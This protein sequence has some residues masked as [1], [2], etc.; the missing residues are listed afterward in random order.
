MISTVIL[1][2][3][4]GSR[5]NI[6]ENKVLLPL[7]GE[8]MFLKA[9]RTLAKISDELI[10]VSNENDISKIKRYVPHVILGGATRQ[11]SVYNGVKEAKGD[12]VIIHDGARPFVYLEDVKSLIDLMATYDVAFI[13]HNVVNSLK[14]LSFKNVDRNKLVEAYTPQIVKRKIYLEAYQKASEKKLTFTDDVTLVNEM[15]NKG[16][17]YVSSDNFYLKVTTFKDYELLLRITNDNYRIGHSWDTHLLALGRKLILGGVQIPF[18]KGLVGHSDA[19]CLLHAIAE[20]LL[21]ALALGDLGTF[22]P[23]NNPKYLGIDSSLLLKE[24][25]KM[26]LD[27]GYKIVNLDT[28]IYAEKPKLAPYILKIR[29]RIAEILEIDIEKVA[30][31]ATTYEHLDAI[32]RGEAIAADSTVLLVKN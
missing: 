13:G 32:G 21:G 29:H 28:M 1:C 14:D 31:K 20:S 3:G 22:F 8:P 15:L 11:E 7:N 10:V 26:V 23:D 19:D 12:I 24:C 6:N 5:M 18:E 4:I 25:Y 30:V 2:G 16:I 9:Y 27:K 17:G